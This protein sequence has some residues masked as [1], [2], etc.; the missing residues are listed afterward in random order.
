MHDAGKSQ[1]R[2]EAAEGGLDEFQGERFDGDGGVALRLTSTTSAQDGRATNARTT[3][4]PTCPVPPMIT[5]RNG[6][7]K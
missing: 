7:S 5:T 4:A 2:H 1:A 6:I 3:A